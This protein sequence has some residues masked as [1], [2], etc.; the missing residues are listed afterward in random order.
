M[1][2]VLKRKHTTAL[3]ASSSSKRFDT[4][5][6][7]N[8][9]HACCRLHPTRMSTIACCLRD[10]H[11]ACQ[12]V[13][14]TGNVVK[15]RVFLRYAAFF[16]SCLPLAHERGGAN[17]STRTGA[18]RLSAKA[19]ANGVGRIAP[20][21]LERIAPPAREGPLESAQTDSPAV[22]NEY[23]EHASCPSGGAR[24]RAATGL[25][26]RTLPC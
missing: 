17:R 14:R 2:S 22:R 15:S 9:Q 8:Q 4:H 19:G 13:S 20:P 6:R 5:R 16:A 11:M 10:E 3:A 21:A 1:H 24:M 25:R 18:N 26:L 12:N 7:R 23:S